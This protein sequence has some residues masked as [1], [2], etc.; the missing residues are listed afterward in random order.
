M[1]SIQQFYEILGVQPG[2]SPEQIQQAY[3]DLVKVW[4]PDRFGSD[5]RLQARAQE[6]LKEINEAYDAVM[7]PRPFARRP[8]APSGA[9]R[10]PQRSSQQAAHPKDA[11]WMM[12]VV[13][14]ITLLLALALVSLMFFTFGDSDAPVQTQ[15]ILNE[16]A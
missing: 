12:P 9:S 11:S 10:P 15:K 6:K 7:S 5:T 2:A 14:I 4:H 13:S 3:H 1:R 16:S 8:S